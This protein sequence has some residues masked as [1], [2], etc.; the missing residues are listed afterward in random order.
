MPRL[1][2]D[3]AASVCSRRL[4]YGDPADT[5][6]TGYAVRDS[7]A[8]IGFRLDT[9]RL[10]QGESRRFGR[11]DLAE[12]HKPGPGEVVPQNLLVVIVAL[13]HLVRA[14]LAQA[15]AVTKARPRELIIV[16][17][18]LEVEPRALQGCRAEGRY[19]QRPE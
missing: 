12:R 6:V 2:T 9:V 18:S 11:R 14:P 5:R 17:S 10:T 15:H 13:R 3:S 8:R 19:H 16:A 7:P 1:P 4:G